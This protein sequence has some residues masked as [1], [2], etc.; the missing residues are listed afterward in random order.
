[1][2]ACFQPSTLPKPNPDATTAP[3]PCYKHTH[4]LITCLC[5]AVKKHVWTRR[6]R[7]ILVFGGATGGSTATTTWLVVIDTPECID[8]M[9]LIY[10][11]LRRTAAHMAR[12]VTKHDSGE[13]V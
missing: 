10:I 6:K 9:S 5:F 11:F 7:F 12:N 8:F 2:V 13:K 1:M 4:G 3:F